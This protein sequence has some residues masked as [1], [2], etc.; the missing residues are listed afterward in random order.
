MEDRSS[1]IG[2][3]NALGGRGS[4]RHPGLHEHLAGQPRRAPSFRDALV[5]AIELMRGFGDEETGSAADV[6]EKQANKM[7]AR[8]AFFLLPRCHCGA[9]RKKTQQFCHGCLAAIPFSLWMTFH[10]GTAKESGAAM[11]KMVGIARGRRGK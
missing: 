1:K 11:K 10:R 8:E 4:A 7:R 2:V 5:S 6:L 3:R 9:R